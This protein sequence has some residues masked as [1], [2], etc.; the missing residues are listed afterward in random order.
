MNGIEMSEFAQLYGTSL[1]TCLG[2]GEPSAGAAEHCSRIHTT[3]A[4][5]SIGTSRGK[6]PTRKWR[7]A[8]RLLPPSALLLS[9]QVPG[10]YVLHAPCTNRYPKHGTESSWDECTALTPALLLT[11]R[12]CWYRV[13][14]HILRAIINTRCTPPPLAYSQWLGPLLRRHQKLP[15]TGGLQGCRL[16]GLQLRRASSRGEIAPPGLLVIS[17]GVFYSRVPYSP[18]P[19]GCS[20]LIRCSADLGRMLRHAWRHFWEA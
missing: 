1:F 7:Q 13:T 18:L 17:R 14:T 8:A 3:T 15:T 5:P 4:L 10:A 16:R 2:G 6:Y 19:R 20:F 9:Q 11:H 12:T